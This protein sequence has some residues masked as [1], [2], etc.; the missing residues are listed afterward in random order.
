M[1]WTRNT[2]L[3]GFVCVLLVTS[4]LLLLLRTGLVLALWLIVVCVI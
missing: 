2:S 3:L 1:D 4:A